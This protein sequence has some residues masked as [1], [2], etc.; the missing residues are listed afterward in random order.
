[1]NGV[2][3]EMMYTFDGGLEEAGDTRLRSGDVAG[4]FGAILAGD[5]PAKTNILAV[6]RA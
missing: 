3:A 1:M 4:L 2:M 6:E 5:L